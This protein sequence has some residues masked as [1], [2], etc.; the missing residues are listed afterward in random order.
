[1]CLDAPAA[2]AGR[3]FLHASARALGQG[4]IGLLSFGQMTVCDTRQTV[5]GTTPIGNLVVFAGDID[6]IF[7]TRSTFKAFS[8]GASTVASECRRRR[9]VKFQMADGMCRVA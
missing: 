7:D 4:R 8:V 1:M 6:G 3:I 9:S 2:G 5:R